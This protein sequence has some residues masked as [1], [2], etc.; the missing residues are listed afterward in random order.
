MK[1]HPR[2][3]RDVHSTDVGTVIGST[4]AI[5]AMTEA[6]SSGMGDFLLRPERTPEVSRTL[7]YMPYGQFMKTDAWYFTSETAK[8]LAGRKCILCG[9][10]K[11]LNS[12]HLTYERKGGELANDIAVLC[13]T[14][15]MEA[16][17]LTDETKKRRR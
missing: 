13:Q 15:H 8:N 7:F 17:R 14:C 16:H 1:Q 4:F 12:H 5:F 10:T 11:S 9:D 6:Q 2:T 3:A